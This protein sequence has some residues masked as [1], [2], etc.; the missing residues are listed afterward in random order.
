[1][2]VTYEQRSMLQKLESNMEIR[3]L[4]ID[5]VS[6]ED[7]FFKSRL[8]P[9]KPQQGWKYSPKMSGYLLVS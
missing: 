7:R 3:N 6:E 9:A 5:A 4:A 2:L 1:V 8:L